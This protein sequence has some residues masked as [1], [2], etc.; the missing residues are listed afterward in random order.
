MAGH[1]Y[2][3]RMPELPDL[4]VYIECLERR[5]QGATL[6]KVRQRVE[7]CT[8]IC[9]THD[10]ALDALKSLEA[11]VENRDLCHGG[12]VPAILT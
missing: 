7:H 3:G 6:D 4:T 1:S 2:A 11:H 5:I 10:L 9:V 8:A 12:R